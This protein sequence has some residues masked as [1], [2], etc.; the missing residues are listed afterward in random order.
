MV[1]SAHGATI[2]DSFVAIQD[3]GANISLAV[4]NEGVLLGIVTDGDVR[5][6]LLAGRQ[7][8]DPVEDFIQRRPFTVRPEESRTSI[9][10]LMQ[11]RPLPGPRRRP[12]W[13]FGRVAPDEGAA[14]SGPA[15]KRRNDSCG[16]ARFPADADDG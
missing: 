7:L 8:A 6:A 2:R 12:A 15:T 14:R 16:G 1:F 10:D 5:R 9:L 11:A 4:D 3:G 13:G